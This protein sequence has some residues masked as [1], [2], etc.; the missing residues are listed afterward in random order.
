MI[1]RE[2][3]QAD[4]AARLFRRIALTVVCV[5]FAAALLVDA[6][7]SLNSNSTR[8]AAGAVATIL[9]YGTV[10]WSLVTWIRSGRAV[11]A[12]R[13]WRKFAVAFAALTVAYLGVDVWDWLADAFGASNVYQTVLVVGMATAASTAASREP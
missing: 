4:P 12:G 3:E 8:G 7:V 13:A 10:G 5:T 6:L 2:A 1:D 11:P 9:F